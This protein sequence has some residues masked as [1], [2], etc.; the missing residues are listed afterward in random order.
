MVR[1]PAVEANQAW[2]LDFV[3]D[4]L[5]SGRPFR[6][7]AVFDE[8]SRESLAIEVDRSLTSARV[9][10]VLERLGVERGLPILI[11]LITGP[12]SPVARSTNGPILAIPPSRSASPPPLKRIS[13][14]SRPR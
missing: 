1:P 13:N 12:S 10:R 2:A 14:G 8:W 5:V 7:L 4:S 3:H 6:A 9:I 11:S